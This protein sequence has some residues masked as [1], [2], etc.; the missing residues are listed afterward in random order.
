MAKKASKIEVKTKEQ[1]F[2]EV[3]TLINS[4]SVENGRQNPLESVR[5][6]AEDEISEFE[7]DEDED[8]DEEEEE[9]EE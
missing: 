6:W 4:V 5:D 2:D 3:K 8:E 1:V 7:Q 9:E